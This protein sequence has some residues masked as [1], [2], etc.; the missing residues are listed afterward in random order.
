[1]RH[2]KSSNT[3]TGCKLRIEPSK[4]FVARTGKDIREMNDCGKHVSALIGK[5]NPIIHGKANYM[6][7]KVA[8]ETLL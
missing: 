6:N 2:Y 8:S 3:K 4:E 7:N 1:M 5:I